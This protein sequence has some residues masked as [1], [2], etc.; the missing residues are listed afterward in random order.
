[1][2]YF[3]ATIELG[4]SFCFIFR[5]LRSST[6]K[7]FFSSSPKSGSLFVFRFGADIFC[8][9]LH[10]LPKCQHNHIALAAHEGCD[11]RVL[12]I[13][14]LPAWKMRDLMQSAHQRASCRGALQKSALLLREALF[15][16]R[17]N[18]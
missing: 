16:P 10:P 14:G 9:E 3:L 5:R 12:K 1:M 15:H 11:G 4:V 18:L 17:L 7:D 8:N 6:K 2:P 13:F